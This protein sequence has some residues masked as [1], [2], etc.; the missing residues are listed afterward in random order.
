MMGAH[1]GRSLHNAETHS[2]RFQTYGGVGACHQCLEEMFP[3]NRMI[4]FDVTGM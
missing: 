1:Q 4:V 2:L 3:L